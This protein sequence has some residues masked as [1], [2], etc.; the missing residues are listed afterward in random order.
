MLKHSSAQHGVFKKSI[1]TFVISWSGKHD[2]AEKIVSE[3]CR[4]SDSVT[5]IYSDPDRTAQVKFSCPGIRRPNDL[6][7]GDKFQACVDSCDADILLLIH[8]DCNSKNWSELPEHCRRAVE[9]NPDI[10]VWAP[11]VDFADW[12][13]DR[14]E[15]DK[16]PNSELSIVA[17]TDA[18][19]FALTREIVDR[20]RKA[21]FKRNIYGWGA[22]F[23]FNYYTYS[24]GMISVVDRSI[25]V[26]H[27]RSTKYSGE[28]AT[29]QLEE[30]LKQLTPAERNQSALLDGIVKLRDRIKEAGTEDLTAVAE[31]ERELALLSRRILSAENV[32]KKRTL[33][34]VSGAVRSWIVDLRGAGRDRNPRRQ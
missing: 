27:P 19:V 6:F 8:A 3:V 4:A 33:T 9:Q 14:T 17:Q 15:I 26:K 22:D 18:V 25:L 2:N 31:A 34:G 11:R 21:D 13:L 7:F 23:M 29:A 24:V 5:V 20:M 12:S 28:I 16:M 1:H 32:A 30:F 10:G